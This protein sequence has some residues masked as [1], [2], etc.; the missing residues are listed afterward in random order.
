MA[1]EYPS[2]DD[3][4][5]AYLSTCDLVPAPA[6]QQGVLPANG[7]QYA[8]AHMLPNTY[9][10]AVGAST[11]QCPAA[12][13]ASTARHQPGIPSRWEQGSGDVYMQPYDQMAHQHMS[14]NQYPQQQDWQL[15]QQQLQLLHEQQQQQQQHQQQLLQL[16]QQAAAAQAAAAQA[17]E[18]QSS[19]HKARSGRSRSPKSGRQSGSSSQQTQQQESSSAATGRRNGKSTGS[20]RGQKVK[21]KQE[22]Q[23]VNMD[24][25]QAMMYTAMDG[26]FATPELGHTASAP[27]ALSHAG[28]VPAQAAA[29]A[30]YAGSNA[31]SFSAYG[32]QQAGNLTNVLMM[33]QAY[34]QQAMQQQ[35]MQQ[36]A[37]GQMQPRAVPEA[38]VPDMTHLTVMQVRVRLRCVVQ[39]HGASRR[40]A[41]QQMGWASASKQRALKAYQ[42][43][44]CAG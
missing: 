23:E 31:A 37:Q 26:F 7:L 9:Q 30:A 8:G 4:V 44:S 22:Q 42:Q 38:D 3:F 15:Q 17:A 24:V 6:P 27:A 2:V 20:A 19:S 43:V 13:Q 33:R 35:A 32:Q 16:Q 36:Q 39:R 11:Q 1:S 10:Q 34:G 5:A 41:Q 40:R 18:L 25:D 28:A 29:A 12:A 14:M 21:V